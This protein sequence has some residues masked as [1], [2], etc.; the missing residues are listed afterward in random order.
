MTKRLENY[1][2]KMIARAHMAI[3]LV[4]KTFTEE[5]WQEMY[6][7]DKMITTESYHFYA[8]Y[9]FKGKDVREERTNSGKKR[10]KISKP[11][12]SFYIRYKLY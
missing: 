5:Q 4:M 9:M 2:T 6:E 11:D 1:K 7:E 12:G 3:R 10:Y 8:S